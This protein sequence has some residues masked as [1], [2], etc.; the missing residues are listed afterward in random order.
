MQR[1]AWKCWM[2]LNLWFLFE[3]F[4]IKKNYLYFPQIYTT[5]VSLLIFDSEFQLF[6]KRTVSEVITQYLYDFPSQSGHL[7]ENTTILWDYNAI[8]P[9]FKLFQ[10]AYIYT[11][12]SN[13]FLPVS[14]W[15]QG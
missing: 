10:A 15:T 9:S 7:W 12:Y 3:T 13:E 11:K 14:P 6:L 8:I 4:L 5:L 1:D 2:E